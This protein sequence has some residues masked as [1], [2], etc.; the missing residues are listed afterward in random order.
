MPSIL[1]SLVK[2]FSS[3]IGNDSKASEANVEVCLSPS[4]VGRK[5]S[6]TANLQ[7]EISQSRPEVFFEGSK[8]TVF[9]TIESNDIE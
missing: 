4:N 3:D 8:I 9:N 6:N 2:S 7:V 1:G 5:G